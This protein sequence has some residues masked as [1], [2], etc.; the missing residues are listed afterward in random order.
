MRISAANAFLPTACRLLPCEGRTAHAENT[1]A[2]S[3]NL[4]CFAKKQRC[5]CV[6][7]DRLA[8]FKLMNW[9]SIMTKYYLCKK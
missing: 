1:A 6:K 8:T 9:I 2:F 3:R 5:F 4:P 7:F